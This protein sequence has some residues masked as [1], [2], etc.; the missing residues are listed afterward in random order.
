MEG[1]HN[2]APVRTS[3]LD[4]RHLHNPPFDISTRIIN[5]HLKKNPAN[6][7]S[8]PPD[9]VT[10]LFRTLHAY[11][12]LFVKKAVL[13]AYKAQVR[14]T[15]LLHPDV[16]SCSS[17]PSLSSSHTVLPT[18]AQIHQLC[19][20]CSFQLAKYCILLQ[21]KLCWST[22]LLTHLSS[23]RLLSHDTSRDE[24]LQQRSMACQ[25]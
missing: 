14:S 4:S 9:H 17:H 23:L 12:P 18:T 8:F 7:G 20:G 21:T 10:S 2:S 6:S 24:E 25:V 19:T 1:S 11:P 22:D 13:G 16:I 15:I 3:S 5:R